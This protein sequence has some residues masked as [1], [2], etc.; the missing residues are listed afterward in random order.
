VFGTYS[1]A[2]FD[3]HHVVFKFIQECMG[4]TRG[5]PYDYSRIQFLWEH[6]L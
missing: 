4:D 5:P 2:P 6:N 1:E 3:S